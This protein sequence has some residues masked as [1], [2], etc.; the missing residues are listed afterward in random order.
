MVRYALGRVLSSLPTLL[1]VVTITFLMVRAL[2]GDPALTMLGEY[3]TEES[4][5][6]L[7]AKLNLDQP[8]L[9]Q[10][11][12]YLRS[13]ALL[14]FG[15]SAITRQPVL[16][17]LAPLIAPSIVLAVGGVLV[18]VLIG[19]PAGVVSAVRQGT[20]T[21]YLLMAITIAGISLPVF[22]LGLVAIVI[23][24]SK[25]SILPATGSGAPGD[26][27]S[28]LR[29]L[30]LPACVLGLGVAAYIARLTRS[31]MLEVLRQN[32]VQVAHALGLRPRRI[33]LR[34]ALRNA[35][36]PILGVIGVSFSWAIGNAILVEAVFSRSGLGSI[37]L[38]GVSSR[39]YQLVQA[40]VLILAIFVVAVN[41]SLDV[42]YGVID[43]RRRELR[44]LRGG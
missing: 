11:F 43:P 40:G 25:L 27:I 5:A 31:A 36:A 34:Y 26:A 6:A 28:Q 4:V 29:H 16:Q 3:A 41:I 15:D 39:D 9:V 33:V 32:Y 2:P 17:V 30:I 24:A 21:D 23:F 44:A 14:D 19:V 35:M 8:L 10:Y 38:R 7:R 1:G 18:A 12:D 42:A 22:W 20:A 13:V 37:I